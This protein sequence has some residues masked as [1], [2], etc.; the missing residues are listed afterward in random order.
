II[1]QISN[2]DPIQFEK[3]LLTAAELHRDR[4]SAALF[5]SVDDSFEPLEIIAITAGGADGWNQSLLPPAV[6]IKPFRRIKTQVLPFVDRL[7]VFITGN[8]SQ[9]LEKLSNVN[10]FFRGQWDIVRTPRISG[11]GI[12]TGTSVPA[13][14][15][16]EFENLEIVKSFLGQSPA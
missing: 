9:F 1:Q 8:D 5:V 4:E 14:F 2:R 15:R 6:N 12:L 11:N 7:A 13:G 16:F 3:I 10:R